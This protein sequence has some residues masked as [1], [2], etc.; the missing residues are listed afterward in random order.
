MVAYRGPCCWA[1][2]LQCGL[3]QCR[4]KA[5]TVPSAACMG[6]EQ[7]C[8]HRKDHQVLSRGIQA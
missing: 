1:P 6:E 3:V 2:G 4:S 8:T 5:A 7:H